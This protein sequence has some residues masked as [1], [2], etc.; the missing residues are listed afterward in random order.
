MMTAMGGVMPESGWN[1]AAV[2]GAMGPMAHTM[3][4]GGKVRLRG[5]TPNGQGF[6]A[7]PPQIWLVA[8][9]S[10]YFGQ[11]FGEP[12]PLDEQTR[13]G[14]L[15]LPQRG[16]FLVGRARFTPTLMPSYDQGTVGARMGQ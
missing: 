8:E 2:L 6:K 1:S 12:A 10:A 13:L 15:W 7:A 5:E 14:D 3:L 11:D 4:R 16:I 9:S